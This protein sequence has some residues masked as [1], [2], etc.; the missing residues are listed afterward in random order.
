VHN[1][2]NGYGAT[3][4]WMDA[5]NV[6]NNYSEGHYYTA[7]ECSNEGYGFRLTSFL[8]AAINL[9]GFGGMALP[10]V[11]PPYE[12]LTATCNQRALTN[13]GRRLLERMMQLGMLIDIDHMGRKAL[14]ETLTLAS[15]FEVQPRPDAE[16]RGKCTRPPHRK[17]P[18]VGV[19]RSRAHTGPSRRS[20]PIQ[21]AR[22]HR[23]KWPVPLYKF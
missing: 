14:D 17:L 6:G 15:S 5:I 13:L 7:E 2:N 11:F 3:A 8:A 10:A 4:T 12:T 22:L 20:I 1:F 18:R 16:R 9:A 23:R 21:C 19:G